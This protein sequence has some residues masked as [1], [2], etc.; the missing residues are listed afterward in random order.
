MHCGEFD[1]AAVGFGALIV[2]G[3]DP[4]ELLQLG[5]KAF[6]AVASGVEVAIIVTLVFA[7]SAWRDDGRAP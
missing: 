5:E 2:V 3:C 4:A 7:V 1:E 6:D